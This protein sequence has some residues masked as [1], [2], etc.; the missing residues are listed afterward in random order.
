MAKLSY[1][2]A[3]VLVVASVLKSSVAEAPEQLPLLD[4]TENIYANNSFENQANL[5]GHQPFPIGGRR[6]L[7]V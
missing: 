2:I 7:R 5:V 3:I 4:P 6:P 1:L